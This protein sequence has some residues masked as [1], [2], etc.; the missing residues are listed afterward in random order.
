MRRIRST[1]NKRRAEAS[2]GSR[3][4]ELEHPLRIGGTIEPRLQKA[5]SGSN[6]LSREAS[7]AKVD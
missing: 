4:H 7:S 6:Q 3:E 2:L 1:R 5:A